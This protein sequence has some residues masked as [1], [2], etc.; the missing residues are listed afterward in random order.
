MKKTAALAIMAAIAVSSG[1]SSVSVQASTLSRNG[2]WSQIGTYKLSNNCKLFAFSFNGCLPEFGLPGTETPDTEVPDTET[3]DTEVPD[4]EAPGTETPDTD[5]SKPET[6]YNKPGTDNNKPGTDDSTNGTGNET[7]SFAEQVVKL[8]NEER[9]KA[10]LS[11]VTLDKSITSAAMVR[12]KEIQTSFSHTRPDGR[13]FSTALTDQNISYRVA[14]EK[15]AGGQ[16]TPEAVMNAWMNSEG[17]RA[18]ILNA[19]FTKIGVGYLKNASGT[20][21][22]TQLFT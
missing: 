16:K 8:V 20:N 4:T 14:G 21:Y 22:W 1:A 3:P 2:N 11:K 10:G 6:D 13:K 7:V 17:H 18:N 15:I 5:T 9:V 12:T 19:Q